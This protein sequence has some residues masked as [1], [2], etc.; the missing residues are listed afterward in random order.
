MLVSIWLA[1]EGDVETPGTF[2]VRARRVG[3]IG[4]A[5]GDEVYV[6]NT[7]SGLLLNVMLLV[8]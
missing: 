6:R 2:E 3:R 1:S 4:T 7:V 5:V 8:T